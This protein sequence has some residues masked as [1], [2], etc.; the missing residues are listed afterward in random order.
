MAYHHSLHLLIVY[1]AIHFSF[2]FF[3]LA[4]WGEISLIRC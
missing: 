3:L 4:R 2:L 1:P